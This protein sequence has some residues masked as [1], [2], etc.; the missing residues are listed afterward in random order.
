LF[1][2]LSRLFFMMGVDELLCQIFVVYTALPVASLLPVY[3][4]KYDPDP[5]N[6]LDAAGACILSVILSA[7]TIPVWF[8]LL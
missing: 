1:F 5:D 2:L 4:I 7:V 6:H 3:S 8:M